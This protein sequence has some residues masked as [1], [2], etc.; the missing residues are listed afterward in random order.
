MRA[1][2]FSEMDHVFHY[3]S[4]AR[5]RSYRY[6]DA[7]D[8]PWAHTS[9]NVSLAESLATKVEREAPARIGDGSTCSRRSTYKVFYEPVMAQSRP[10]FII[11]LAWTRDRCAFIQR[12]GRTR[13]RVQKR[14]KHAI[15]VFVRTW[16]LQC[17]IFIRSH[18]FFT[19]ETIKMTFVISQIYTFN[20]DLQ[21]AVK[22][23]QSV[24]EIARIY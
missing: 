4:Y 9:Y 13:L 2:S 19:L 20:D 14:A 21:I 23:C 15:S 11:S 10:L 5:V 18:M 24:L 8:P 16:D 22:T 1:R 3:A 7:T 12:R 6:M 17:E